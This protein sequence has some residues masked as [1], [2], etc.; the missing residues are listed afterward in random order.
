MITVSALAVQTFNTDI[1]F[2][3]TKA[4]GVANEDTD[5]TLSFWL[6]ALILAGGS[7]GVCIILV[8]LGYRDLRQIRPQA[9][10]PSQN[11]AWVS[12]RVDRKSAAGPN[13]VCLNKH[14]APPPRLCLLH[15]YTALC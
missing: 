12:V 14:T 1:V 15:Q 3:L 11:K 7:S 10:Q 8:A 5:K 6:T 13:F 2:E 4:Y 9:A